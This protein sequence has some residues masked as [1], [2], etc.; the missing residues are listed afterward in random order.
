MLG[1]GPPGTPP[2][3]ADQGFQNTG[4]NLL[5]QD[6]GRYATDAYGIPL[7]YTMQLAQGITI[8]PQAN[9]CN[10]VQI[11][12]RSGAPICDAN[13]MVINPVDISQQRVEIGG[14]MKSP[15]LRN[16]AL[17]PPYFHYGGYSN[18]RDIMDFYNRGGSSRD[19]P[20]G[21]IPGPGP[22]TTCTGDTSGSG[23]L[24]QTAFEDI[25]EGNEGSN[26]AG[27]IAARG[28]SGPTMDNIVEF[29]K[30]LSDPRVACDAGPFDHPE[31]VIFTG[32]KARDRNRDHRADDKRVRIPAVG[33]DGYADTK[34]D[35][36]LPHAGDLFEPAMGNRIKD[37]R[38]KAATL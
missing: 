34:P 29:M 14:A 17:T 16:V 27:A 22:T 25:E 3:L 18:L 11:G 23:P 35:L 7:A 1:F 2:V 10:I 12:P 20:E 6:L 15:S 33:I 36:C 26:V 30:A 32:Y 37:G 19:L 9:I 28:M 8:E 31:L 24:G 38:K 4:A 13:G 5:S 21:C